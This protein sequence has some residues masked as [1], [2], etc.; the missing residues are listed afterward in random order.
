MGLGLK[1]LLPWQREIFFIDFYSNTDLL[2]NLLYKC[3]IFFCNIFF[4]IIL[5]PLTIIM[6]FAKILQPIMKV[7]VAFY[8]LHYG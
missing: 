1:S 4:Q 6:L 3:C 2:K 8:Y 5:S 7:K